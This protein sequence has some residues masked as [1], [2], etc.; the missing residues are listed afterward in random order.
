MS[1]KDYDSRETEGLFGYGN[2]EFL[3]SLSLTDHWS[4][5]ASAS[6]QKAFGKNLD[7]SEQIIVTGLRGVKAYS[8]NV[9][10]DN[11]YVLNAELKYKL[12]NILQWEHALGG[13]V[14]YGEWSYERPP[15]PD[16]YS[17]DM[18]DIGLGYYAKFGL[19]S[20]KVQLVQGLGDYPNGLKKES[21]T[22]VCT[23]LMLSF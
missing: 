17:G 18:T 12:P 22:V 10:G 13:F 7:S 19:F 11:G 21:Q 4:L 6:G 2:L 3:S 9:S 23:T 16:P 20:G 14:D 1:G 8:E 15:F 5:T